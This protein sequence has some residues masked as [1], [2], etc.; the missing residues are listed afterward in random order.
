MS[1]YNKFVLAATGVAIVLMVLLMVA[2]APAPSAAQGN[3]PCYRQQGGAQWVAGDGCE[4]EVQDNGSLQLQAGATLDA[5]IGSVLMAGGYFLAPAQTPIAVT[6]SAPIAPVGLF[7]PFSSGAVTGLTLTVGA[8]GQVYIYMNT[9]SNAVT[10]TDTGTTVL[11]GNFA[12]GQYDVLGVRSDG[13]RM[14]ELF[15]SNN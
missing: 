10:I 12:M 2:L 5:Q 3:V 4:W 11:G 8:A 13:T 7:Q 9:G 1:N 15:R 14:I 6:P